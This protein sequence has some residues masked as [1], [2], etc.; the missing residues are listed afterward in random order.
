LARTGDY[1]FTI[2]ITNGFRALEMLDKDL[3]FFAVNYWVRLSA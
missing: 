3:E 2:D 1:L